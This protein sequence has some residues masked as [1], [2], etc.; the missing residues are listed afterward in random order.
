MS[1]LVCVLPAPLPS[2]PALALARAASAL[3]PP[4]TK[5]GDRGE[6]PAVGAALKGGAD[7]RGGGGGVDLTVVGLVI[8]QPPHTSTSCSSP[9][10]PEL[11]LSLERAVALRLFDGAAASVP[12]GIL[13]PPTLA[14]LAAIAL[15]N[16]ALARFSVLAPPPPSKGSGRWWV[17]HSFGFSLGMV[18]GE[19]GGWRRIRPGW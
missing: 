2:L 8:P 15:A 12:D 5:A 3:L 19:Y 14:A 13:P 16:A 17:D 1:L 6:E 9:S 18:D 4:L 10:S 11:L 7:T